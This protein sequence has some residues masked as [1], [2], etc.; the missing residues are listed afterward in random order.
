MP[1][2]GL[3]VSDG[4]HYHF[5]ADRLKKISTRLIPTRTCL[6]SEDSASIEQGSRSVTQQPVTSP[7]TPDEPW[8]VRRVLEWTT[9]HLKKSGSDTPRLDAEILLA[10]ARGCQRI[11]LYTQFDEPL[12]DAVRATMRGL[13]QRRA[14]A[15]PVA[16]LVGQREFFSLKFRVTHDVL[17][18]RPDTETLVIEILDAAKMWSSPAILDLCTGSGCVAIATAKNNLQAKVTAV[19]ISS[20]AIEIARENAATHQ[21]ADRVEIIESNLFDAIPADTKFNLIVGNPPYIPS[22]EIEQ[23]EAE[24]ANHEPRLAL[25][26]GPDGMDI[27]RRIIEQAPRFAAPSGLLLLEFTPEQADALEQMTVAHG[28]YEN[29]SIVKD[30]G[31][32]ARVLKAR[33]RAM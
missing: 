31:H 14:K 33:F 16:Y 2:S 29:V 21:V 27:L 22:A 13:V 24:V 19:D 1:F 17:I 15:E 20:A 8:T 9:T 28:A 11:Q 5:E 6:P 12:S 32:R 25:D 18:P 10:H 4:C 3:R 26:G 7:S 23:L 30:L